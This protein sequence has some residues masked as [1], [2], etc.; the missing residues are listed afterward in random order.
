MHM[1]VTCDGCRTK[2]LLG[3]DKVPKTPIR[4]RC[5][6]CRFVWLLSPPAP[7]PAFEVVSS[8]YASEEPVA[9]ERV[10]GV[11]ASVDQQRTVGVGEPEIES[12]AEDV[13]L[14]ERE[15]APV[16][17]QA[18]ESPEIRK[19]KERAKRQA[20]VFVSDILIYNREKRDQGLANGDLMAVLGTEI[21][22]AWEAYKEKVGPELVESSTYF[23]NALNEILADGQKIF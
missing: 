2:Y 22:K 15:S 23:R 9:E 13:E 19:K 21:K 1:I 5:P 14:S 7:E 8:V 18:Q 11:W 17:P 10:S 4:V 6:K 20:R 3:D 16:E 12:P